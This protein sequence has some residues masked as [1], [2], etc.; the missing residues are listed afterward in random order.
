MIYV[1]RY[2]LAALSTV[3][4]ASLACIAA[5]LDRSGE[6]MVWMGRQ[7]IRWIFGGCGIRVEA[8]GVENIDPR[9]PYVFMTNHQSV[10]DIGAIIQTIPVSWRFVAKKELTWIPIF[11]WSLVLAGHV[12]INRGKRSE[13]VSSLKRAAERVAEGVNV[14]IFP[15][16][17][18][19]RTGD[20]KAFKSG[21]FHLAI[22]IAA[23]STPTR[24]KQK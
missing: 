13:A 7:W 10:I 12:I 5:P 24:P 22:Q 1:L 18:R 23:P 14:I 6:S 2:L 16:G 11:G 20:L 15:E 4:W 3:I 19:S 8:E 17:S 9:Q 21:G